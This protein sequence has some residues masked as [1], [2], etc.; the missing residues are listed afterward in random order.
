MRIPSSMT[1]FNMQNYTVL[2]MTF[3][4]Y[5]DPRL[6]GLINALIFI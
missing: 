1:G 3:Y 2:Y 5:I 4:D 6:N